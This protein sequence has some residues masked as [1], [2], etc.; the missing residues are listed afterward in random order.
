MLATYAKWTLRI[1]PHYVDPSHK[2][3]KIS[4]PL[5]RRDPL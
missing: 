4:G 2:V 5:S 1:G 3:A